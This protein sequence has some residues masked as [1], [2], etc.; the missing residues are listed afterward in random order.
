MPTLISHRS[1]R[2][3]K[4]PCVN[5]ELY[6]KYASPG[7]SI[8]HFLVPHPPHLTRIPH[9]A[10]IIPKI[11]PGEN[12]KYQRPAAIVRW[13]DCFCLLVCPLLIPLM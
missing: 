13:I 12:V 11:H 2:P 3:R 7:A 5:H 9:Y 4:I 8:Q 6:L 10:Y 1:H